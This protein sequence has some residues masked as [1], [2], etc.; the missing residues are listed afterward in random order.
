M[1]PLNL[2]KRGRAGISDQGVDIVVLFLL[3][4]SLHSI[5]LPRFKAVSCL[6]DYVI[7]TSVNVAK[8]NRMTKVLTMRNSCILL[9][10]F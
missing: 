8:E 7:N 3:N 2:V 5:N 10:L 6:G 9:P 4:L 1:V